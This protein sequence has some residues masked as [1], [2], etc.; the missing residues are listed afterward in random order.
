MFIQEIK[1]KEIKVAIPL[2]KGTDKTRIKKRSILNEYGIP[3]STKS[4]P[5]SQSCYVEWQIGYD[6]I[7]SDTEKLKKTTLQDLRFIGAN[8]KEKALYELSEY[9]KYFYDWNI[10]TQQELIDIKTYLQNMTDDDFLDNPIGHPE[11]SIKRTNF[12]QKQINGF[13]FM[14]TQ[15]EYPLLVYKFG[16][17]EIITEIIIKEKQYAIGIQPMLYLCFPITELENSQNL[18][19]RTANTKEFS[20]FKIDRNNISVFVDMLKLFGTLSRNHNTDAISIID[21]ILQ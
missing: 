7:A 10:V 8:G 19:G 5:F 12:V 18:L 4:E 1:N 21:T 11:L 13:K 9:I 6:V 3:V 17:F 14:W 16:N 2:T 15:V 20:S